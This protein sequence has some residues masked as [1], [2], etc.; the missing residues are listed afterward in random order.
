M[1]PLDQMQF[2]KDFDQ[3]QKIS[4]HQNVLSF[5]GICQ[6]PDWLYIV[7]E[8]TAMT[9]KQRLIESRVPPNFDP[10]RFSSLSEEYILRLLAELSDAMDYLSMHQVNIFRIGF[11]FHS[12]YFFLSTIPFHSLST[13]NCVRTTF[14]W[15]CT[16]KS[17]FRHLVQ[18]HLT[19]STKQLICCVGVLQKCYAFSIIPLRVTYGRLLVWFGNAVV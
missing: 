15:H 10:R 4:S 5:L 11:F 14:I 1:E 13:R 2:L 19:T 16:M 3:I 6:T 7:F 18:R 9:L 17:K 12:T 8:E